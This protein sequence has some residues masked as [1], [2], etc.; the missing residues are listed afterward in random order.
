MLE[1][2]P[3]LAELKVRRVW[4][5]LYP[6][7]P[8]GLPI[9]GYAREASNVLLAVGM[10]GQGFML[11]PGLGKILSSAIVDGPEASEQIFTELSLYRK[12]EGQEML[13]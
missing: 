12:F 4:R 1:L 10:C 7:T 11:G 13:K 5:G 3:R 8:D 9:V 2:Y 6:M